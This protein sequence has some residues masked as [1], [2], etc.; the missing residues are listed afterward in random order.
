MS[1]RSTK[2]N[3]TVR[4]MVLQG[5]ITAQEVDAVVNAANAHLRHGAGVAGA[6]V[7]NGGRADELGLRSIA[8]PAISTGVFGFPKARA[9]RVMYEALRTY[10]QTHPESGLQEVR[11]VLYDRPTLEA[12]LQVWDETFGA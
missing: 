10:F 8:F 3:D 7:R 6:I 2:L 11:L 9:A 1:L 12:F 4:L 5:D